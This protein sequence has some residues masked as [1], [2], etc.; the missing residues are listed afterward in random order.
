MPKMNILPTVSWLSAR[1]SVYK[2]LVESSLNEA[3]LDL[4]SQRRRL[5]MAAAMVDMLTSRVVSLRTELES[6]P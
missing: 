2:S 6:L 5:E 3:V 1:P 4:H